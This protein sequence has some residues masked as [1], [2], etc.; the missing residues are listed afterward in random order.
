[1]WP[2]LARQGFHQSERGRVLVG[3]QVE[4]LT[5]VPRGSVDFIESASG[6]TVRSASTLDVTANRW[7]NYHELMTYPGPPRL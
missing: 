6:A 1:M 5:F 3:S 2:R 7:T 4:A